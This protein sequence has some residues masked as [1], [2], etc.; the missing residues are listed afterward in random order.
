M[1]QTIIDAGMVVVLAIL[2]LSCVGAYDRLTWFLETVPVMLALPLVAW[3]VRRWHLTSLLLVLV[4]V[5]SLVLIYGG[6]YTYARVPLGFWWQDWWGFERNHYD[7]LGHFMQGLV[8]AIITRE[9]LLRHLAAIPRWLLALL[10]LCVPLAVS[11]VYEVLEM[12]AG[13]VSAEAAEAFLGT[14]G[15]VWDTQMDMLLAGLGALSS[16][17]LSRWHDRQLHHHERKI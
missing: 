8:P 13:R 16:L 11:A 4:A 12:V 7:R 17:L 14:Q 2:L 1:R 9:V 15:D 3:G 5:H 6:H 10:C